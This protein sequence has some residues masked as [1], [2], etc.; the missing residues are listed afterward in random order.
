MQV[1]G[2]YFLHS[3]QGVDHEKETIYRGPDRVCPSSGRVGHSGGSDSSEDADLRSD[4][5]PLEAEVCRTGRAGDASAQAGRGREQPSETF[6]GGFD[7]RPPDAPG[8]VVKKA[9]RPA[10]GR[11]LVVQMQESYQVSQRRACSVFRFSRAT[12][13]YQ[14]I[15]DPQ[16]ALR[17]RLCELA[18]SR[19]G[20]GYR[21]LHILLQR[22]G[23]QV[24]HKRVLRIY[25]E[26]GLIMRKKPPRRRVACLKREIR[27]VASKK[28]ECWSMDFVSDQLFD[29][30]RIRVLTL[31]DNHTRESLA[32]HIA[33][34]VRG[35]DVVQVLERVAD[36]HGLP[37]TIR[38]DNGPEFISKD[39]D[40][41]AYWNK[42]KLDFSRP[43][44]PTDNAFIESFNARFRLECLNEHWFLSLDDAQEKIEGWRQDYN[45]TRPHSSLGNLTPNE[46]A[47]R[48]RPSATA[49]P[50]P[51][52]YT[53]VT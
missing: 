1:F 47:I 12:I 3:D 2:L 42:V 6:G 46:F 44:K 26:E 14:S 33:S 10:A 35:R 43:G 29:G 36:K 21:R 41:W 11:T 39:L 25:R 53:G 8:C 19:V 52:A 31:V 38:V 16:I 28:N 37:Q 27:P 15:A 51:A 20:Y 34:R 49:A 45:R 40:L 5:L 24:N 17:L 32:L 13:R 7:V 18:T 22:E 48:C 30:Q 50:S 4:V 9:L 23:W